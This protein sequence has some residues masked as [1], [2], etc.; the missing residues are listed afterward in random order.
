[1]SKWWEPTLT[2]DKWVKSIRKDEPEETKDM[3]DEDV[4]SEYNEYDRKYE[5]LWDHLGDA[6]EEYEYLAD[7][8][9]KLKDKLKQIK[10]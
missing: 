8:Y 7:A 3:T 6:Y 10:K 4:I 1:M 9:L 5:V 2:D